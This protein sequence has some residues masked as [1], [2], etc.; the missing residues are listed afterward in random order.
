M[1][2]IACAAIVSLSSLAAAA[3]TNASPED[4]LAAAIRTRIGASRVAGEALHSG[5][6]LSRIYTERAFAPA[7][8][9]DRRPSQDAK[10]MQGEIGRAAAHGLNPEFYHSSKIAILVNEAGGGDSGPSAQADLDILLTDAFI[11]LGSNLSS[12]LADPYKFKIAWLR[13]NAAVDFNALLEKSLNAHDVDRELELLAPQD[14]AYKDLQK[15]LARYEELASKGGWPTVGIGEKIEPGATDP[16]IA[17]VRKR[18]AAEGVSVNTAGDENLYDDALK[19]AVVHFQERHGLAQDG[20]IGKGTIAAMNATAG[21]RACQVRINLDRMRGFSKEFAEQRSILVNVP[22]F[23]VKVRESGQDILAMKA[24]V[25]RRDRKTPMM[26]DKVRL[27]VF[28][29]RW[30]VPVSIAVKDKLPEIKKDPGF[31]ERHGM[32]LYSEGVEVKADEVDWSSVDAGNFTYHIVQRSGDDNALGRVKFLF[33]N[34]DNVYLHDTPTKGLFQNAVRTFSS[35]CIRIEKPVELAEYLLKGKDGWDRTRIE[36]A[37]ERKDPLYVNLDEPM[38]IHIL[39]LTAW[40]DKD[41][42]SE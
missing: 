32:K 39:Y 33:P 3:P 41:G 2:F 13:P 19:D 10:A 9:A 40:A 27:V 37:M 4:P 42:T 21:W 17:D 8:I 34:K 30:D 15:M 1:S 11:A 24:I 26:S 16:R 14:S 29:P 5:P 20:V 18:L 25:G 7:W 35:G 6:E 38:P 36:E 31:L 12:G 28:S 23:H 22:D